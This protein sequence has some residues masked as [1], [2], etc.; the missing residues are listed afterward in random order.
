[1][2]DNGVAVD[3]ARRSSLT[4]LHKCLHLAFQVST[5]A[6]GAFRPLAVQDD[7]FETVM[8]LIAHKLVNRHGLFHLDE[9]INAAD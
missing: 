5:L 3:G 8:T 7:K 1:M 4:S 2:S 9:I 6:L